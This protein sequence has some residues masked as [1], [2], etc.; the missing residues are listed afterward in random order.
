MGKRNKHSGGELKSVPLSIHVTKCRNI[1]EMVANH[2]GVSHTQPFF[3][4]LEAMFKTEHVDNTR[5]H[6]IK[7]D[8]PI[9]SILSKQS[10]VTTSGATRDVHL[11]QTMIVSPFRWMRGDYGHAL[12]LSLSNTD[13]TEMFQKVQSQHNAA[14]VGSLFSAV[15]SQTKCLHF[16]SIYGVYSGIAQDHTID[17]SDDYADLI[18]RP[19]FTQNIGKFFDLKLA[20]HLQSSTSFKHTRS[21]RPSVSISDDVMQLEHVEDIEGVPVEAETRMGELDIV[22]NDVDEEADNASDTSSVSTSYVFCAKSCA[23]SMDDSEE[24]DLEEDGEPFAWATLHNV[25]V[26]LTIMEKCEGTLYDLMCLHNETMKHIAWITQ[27]MFALAYAQRTIGFTHNDLHANN[28]MYVKTAKEELWY[29]IDG[30]MFRVPTYGYL[31]KIIDFERGVGSIRIT[32]MKQPKTFMSDHFSLNEEAGGQYNVE[33]FYTHKHETIKPNPSFDLVRLATSLF[34]D[35]FPEGPDHEEYKSNP[36]FNTFIRWMTQDDG[37]SVF[38]GKE[39]PQHD[40]YHGFTL[41]KAIARYCKESAI[42]RKE[43]MALVPLFGVLNGAHPVEFD[44]VI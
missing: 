28:V 24:E 30:K 33:P 18:D 19:W 6:G 26:Q 44:V 11:K 17:I 34:W 43:I 36:V 35:F 12:G 3:P 22:M 40:R 2:W 9:Q 5:E 25:P 1:S 4:S 42:P 8:D 32:G 7:L 39:I 20:D 29:K 31:I 21:A 15:L 13:A 16:P 37:T 14:Y 41:Y 10:I 27:V 23:C 38:F